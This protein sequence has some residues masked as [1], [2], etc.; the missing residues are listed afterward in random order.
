MKRTRFSVPTLTALIFTLVSSPILRAQDYPIGTVTIIVPFA[1]GGSTDTLAH[2]LAPRLGQR[3]GKPF[4]IQNRPGDGT[5]IAATALAKATPDGHTLMQATSATLAMNVALYKHLPYDPA[6]DIVPVAL[7]CSIPFA[8]VVNSSLPVYSVANLVKLAKERPLSYGSAGQGTFH[9]LSAE[10]FSTAVGIKMTHLP[11]KGSA[12][13]LNALLAGHIQ[14]MFTDLAP[15]QPLIRSGKLR[16]LGI[17]TA[18]RAATAPEIRPLA[19]VGAPGFDAASWVMLVAPA[20]TPKPILTRL[21][22]EVNA[23]V[24]TAEV[25]RQLVKLGVNPIGRGSL[26]ELQTFVSAEVV[27][28]TKVVQEAGITGSE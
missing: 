6:Q 8:L 3:L 19:E 18:E 25:K 13:A 21:N 17:T 28:W 14:V 11:Y 16:A 9:H 20:K 4:V 22:A 10:L 27:R 7:M 15:S 23:I 26:D 2:V 12:P 24:N 1:T 5:I